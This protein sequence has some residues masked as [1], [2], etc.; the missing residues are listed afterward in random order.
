[1][2]NEFRYP[3][4]ALECETASIIKVFSFSSASLFSIHSEEIDCVKGKGG[5]LYGY[6][7]YGV[8]CSEVE[9]DCMTGDHRVSW[10][11]WSARRGIA[12]ESE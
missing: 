3:R 8:A 7:V 1:M 2:R 5:E 6:C 12:L 10:K 9:I 4:L 11:K